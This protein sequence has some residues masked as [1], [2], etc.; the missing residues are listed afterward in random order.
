MPS[1]NSIL[2]STTTPNA[3]SLIV[4]RTIVSTIPTAT[5]GT[6]TGGVVALAI[7]PAAITH[8]LIKENIGDNPVTIIAY[9]KA[10]V[11]TVY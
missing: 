3:T 8:E 11:G 4:A 6:T 9:E 7:K 2:K 1:V 5:A 10:N